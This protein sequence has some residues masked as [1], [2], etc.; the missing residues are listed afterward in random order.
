MLLINDYETLEISFQKHVGKIRIYEESLTWTLY[1]VHLLFYYMDEWFFYPYKH[2]FFFI[3]QR[4]ITKLMMNLV[5]KT[6]V[7]SENESFPLAYERNIA[8]D[9]SFI[10][11]VSNEYALSQFNKFRISGNEIH[12]NYKYI[13]YCNQIRSSIGD[14]ET[15]LL[16][17]QM[18]TSTDATDRMDISMAIGCSL[19]DSMNKLILLSTVDGDSSTYTVAERIRIFNFIYQSSQMGLINAIE[20]LSNRIDDIRTMYGTQS[21]LQNIIIGMSQ[22][23]VNNELVLS[24]S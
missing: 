14:S 20:L 3:L 16:I 23:I 15:L 17:H 2:G 18:L 21:V 6:N 19:D 22:K 24:V 13:I 10:M 12:Q 7:E 8:L 9:L 11:N 1:R 4:F 5:T